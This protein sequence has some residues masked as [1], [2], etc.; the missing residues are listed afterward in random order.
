[1]SG[2]DCKILD[3][4]FGES[5]FKPNDD[6]V[7]YKTTSIFRSTKCIYR[8]LLQNDAKRLEWLG[9]TCIDFFKIWKVGSKN[10][11]TDCTATLPKSRIYCLKLALHNPSCGVFPV[12]IYKKRNIFDLSSIVK[13][14]N[15][16]AS[17]FVFPAPSVCPVLTH[18]R[19]LYLVCTCFLWWRRA[20]GNFLV[21]M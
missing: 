15:L 6:I 19:M 20:M 16:W 7:C 10:W 13:L 9:S 1:M 5:V 18:S 14:M 21:F 11:T 2:F 4:I 12:F 8:K 17:S 3:V